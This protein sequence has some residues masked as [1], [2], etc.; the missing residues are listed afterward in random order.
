MTAVFV[1]NESSRQWPRLV[2]L[3]ITSPQAESAIP[4]K[5]YPRAQPT[6]SFTLNI[7]RDFPSHFPQCF[8]PCLPTL[9]TP[10]PNKPT[11]IPYTHHI[12]QNV[13]PN[14]HHRPRQSPE[15]RH[16]RTISRSRLSRARPRD[17]VHCSSVPRSGGYCCCGAAVGECVGGTG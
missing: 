2:I 15:R 1:R 16:S 4:S 11:K 13:L 9:P 8:T 12:H 7:A 10:T 5:R 6:I 3:M 14:D 17:A